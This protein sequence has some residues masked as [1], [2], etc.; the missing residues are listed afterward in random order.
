VL[1]AAL[2]VVDREGLQ[3]LTVH[4][5]AKRLGSGTM[6]LY[7]HVPDKQALLE[8]ILDLVLDEI[9]IP[10]DELDHWAERFKSLVRGVR[11]AILR[12]PPVL[13]VLTSQQ[14][15]TPAAL[16]LMEEAFDALRQGG[17]SPVE[18]AHV[19]RVVGSYTI[20]FVSLGDS[21]HLRSRR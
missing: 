18:A 15:T 16:R 19:Y 17:L 10:P 20:G 9:E 14:P 2:Q 7:H 5:V 3:A 12:H 1:R 4:R 13:P 6:S 11:G 8:G 21:G